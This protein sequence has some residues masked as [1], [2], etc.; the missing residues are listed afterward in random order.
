[1]YE[2]LGLTPVYTKTI[3]LIRI[4]SSL[5]VNLTFVQFNHFF[6]HICYMLPSFDVVTTVIYAPLLRH[7]TG[8]SQMIITI[9]NNQ[10]SYTSL[11]Q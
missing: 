9:K 1:V 10:F 5:I 7:S 4:A 3:H 6:C 2:K 8:T 11:K